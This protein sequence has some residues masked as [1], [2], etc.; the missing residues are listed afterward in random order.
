MTGI[1][2]L[3]MVMVVL[4]GLGVVIAEGPVQAETLTIGAAPSL[5]PVFNEIL[6][7][8]EREYG[9]S[10][11]AVYGP[12]QT[13][14]REIEQGVPIDVFL[15]AAVEELE[16]LQKKGL[17]LSG[18]HQ[19]YAQTSLVLVMSATSLATSVSFRDVLPNRTTR[20]AIGDPGT[21]ALGEITAR[22]LTKLNPM[23]K[24][25]Y[26][27]LHSPHSEDIVNLLHRG[28]ADMGIVYRVDAINSGQVRIIDENPMEARVPI[29]F[30]AAVLSTCREASRG[31]AEEF[32]DFMGSPRMQ[33]LLLK[34]GFDS[35]PSSSVP[36]NGLRVEASNVKLKP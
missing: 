33:K 36:S 18:G 13:L 22:S 20:I 28:E 23:Y 11:R 35:V 34:Y 16:K 8:F 2:R 17:I 5:R 29:R 1:L 24:S 3:S 32:L 10:V 25:H 26:R 15:P 9:A 14:R 6:P 12:S 27:L 21:S 7:M 4:G 30:G 31:V 19:S